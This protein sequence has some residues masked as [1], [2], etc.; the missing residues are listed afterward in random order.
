MAAS[1]DGGVTVS[2]EVGG[3]LATQNQP[4]LARQDAGTWQATALTP[5]LTAWG[6]RTSANTA[7]DFAGC[8]G[9]GWLPSQVTWFQY[10]RGGEERRGLLPQDSAAMTCGVGAT[11]ALAVAYGGAWRPGAASS[12]PK[13][14]M[15]GQWRC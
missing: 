3:S 10:A 7:G 12:S 5:A 11:G 8:H 4:W 13:R 2:W 6:L 9:E 14:V 1:P 15:R